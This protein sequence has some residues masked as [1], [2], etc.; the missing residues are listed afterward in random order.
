S[1]RTDVDRVAISRDDLRREAE[2]FLH[3]A[4]E[5][6]DLAGF[7]EVASSLFE[8]VIAPVRGHIQ[9]CSSLVLAPDPILQSAPFAA[10]W[11][12]DRGAYL[13]EEFTIQFTP[14]ATAA[15]VAGEKRR[16]SSTALAIA[17][18]DG[19]SDRGFLPNAVREARE[20]LNIYG[21]GRLLIG[22]EV[23]KAAVLDGLH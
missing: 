10:L 3:A 19:S 9:D 16:S 1:D 17:V 20:V 5:S 6:D 15:L 22:S 12:R 7:R 2:L 18:N 11:D 21:R 14:S 8:R 13:V 23:T 4:S